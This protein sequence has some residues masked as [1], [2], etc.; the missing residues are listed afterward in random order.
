MFVRRVQAAFPGRQSARCTEAKL[1]TEAAVA[2]AVV[3]PVASSV[4]HIPVVAVAIV[5]AVCSGAA[6]RRRWPV[7]SVRVFSG[8]N[9]R[10]NFLVEMFPQE[11]RSLDSAPFALVHNIVLVIAA[12]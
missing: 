4:P 3:L 6:I 11:S 9:S 12:P 1:R 10:E 2:F 5:V 7:G 8:Q